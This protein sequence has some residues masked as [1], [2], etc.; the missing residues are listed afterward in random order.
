MRPKVFGPSGSGRRSG[1]SSRNRR[2]KIWQ[3]TIQLHVEDT[4]YIGY[5]IFGG[6]ERGSNNVF[7]VEVANRAAANL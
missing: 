5:W 3:K 6:I 1:E 2:I 4:D 7:M